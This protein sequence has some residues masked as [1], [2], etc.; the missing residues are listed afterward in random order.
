M[1]VVAWG[2][3]CQIES[4]WHRSLEA[5]AGSV[6]DDVVEDA[7][8]DGSIE[9]VEEDHEHRG[10]RDYGKQGAEV[11]LDFDVG[12]RELREKVEPLQHV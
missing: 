6:N 4:D 10:H 8:P 3:D 11:R 7:R 1:D 2:K 5:N 12:I 9:L